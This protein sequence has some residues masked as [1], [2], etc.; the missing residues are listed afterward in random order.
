MA[1][2]ITRKALL[3]EPDEFITF[4]TKLL[5]LA[6]KHQTQLI[7][8]VSAAVLI[9]LVFSGYSYFNRKSES[10]AY[11]MLENS[12]REY[13]ISVKK[14]GPE[15][16]LKEVKD[17]FKNIIDKYSGNSGGKIAR[18]EFANICYNAGDIDTAIDLYNKAL[19]DFSNN[20]FIKCGIINSLG[21]ASEEK[22]DYKSAVAYFEKIVSEPDN[23]LK[24]EAYFNLGRLF[25]IMEEGKK[26]KEAYKKICSDF[27]DSFYFMIAKEYVS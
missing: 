25:A 21:Y 11:S 22:K 15:K 18:L 9:A 2:K 5:N 1:K 13:K 6:G 27:P 12:M 7:S 26:S 4:S 24:D 14:N 20:R 19:I 8:I 17:S 23:S 16:A 10:K 3:K